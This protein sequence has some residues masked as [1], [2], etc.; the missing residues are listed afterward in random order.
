M[1]VSYEGI[2]PR[3][4]VTADPKYTDQKETKRRPLLVVSKHLFQQNSH[5]AVCVGITT[6]IQSNAYLVPIPKKEIED[7]RLDH[8]S[9]VMCHRIVTLRQSELSKSIGR[10]TP[11]FYEKIINKLKNDV[12]GS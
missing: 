1:T 5:Y 3:D 6:S 2:R 8:E 4:I 9:Q 11:A 12:L 10:V 7:G